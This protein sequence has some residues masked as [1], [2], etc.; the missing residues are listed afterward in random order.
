[1]HFDASGWIEAYKQKGALWIYDPER[2]I[3][4][5]VLTSGLHSNRFLNSRLIIDDPV[6]LPKAASDL[7]DLFTAE[8]GDLSSINGI[9][10]PQTGA[11]RLAE[12]MAEQAGY[13]TFHASPRKE[14]EGDAKRMVLTEAEQ[15]QI[16]GQDA[17]ICED[18]VTTA[19]SVELTARAIILA[20]GRVAPY[21]LCLVNRSGKTEIGGRKIISLFT[22]EATTW[23][24][25]AI[26]CDLCKACSIPLVKP[27]DNWPALNAVRTA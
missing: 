23:H 22:L 14:G 25:G 5:P 12:L 7:L 24:P 16:C 27:K 26:T 18:V 3:H 15:A 19:G 1:M 9:V 21:I 10:G 4:H 6:L 8:G 13:G 11:T 17:I 2:H 20:G